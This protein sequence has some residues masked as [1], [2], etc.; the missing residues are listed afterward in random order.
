ME[1][2]SR[3]QT[4]AAAFNGGKENWSV[5]AAVAAACTWFVADVDEEMV[6]DDERSCYNC[7]YRRWTAASFNCLKGG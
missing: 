7:R 4:G 3:D 1:I 6:A 2:W 5:A